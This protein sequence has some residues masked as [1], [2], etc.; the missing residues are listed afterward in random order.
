MSGKFLS[1]SPAWNGPRGPGLGGYGILGLLEWINP[2]W[3]IG[4]NAIEAG[5]VGRGDCGFSGRRFLS[6]HHSDPL[7]ICAC[8]VEPGFGDNVNSRATYRL[9]DS[10]CLF[11]LPAYSPPAEDSSTADRSVGCVSKFRSLHSCIDCHFP[12]SSQPAT[13]D[14]P[15]C[16]LSHLPSGAQANLFL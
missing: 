9:R 4:F 12:K 2:F 15:Q 8:P 11:R 14:S 3:R 10:G 1:L 16:R 5:H 7:D 13:A 6:R